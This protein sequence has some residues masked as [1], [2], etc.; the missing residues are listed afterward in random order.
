MVRRFKE[1][2]RYGLVCAGCGCRAYVTGTLPNERPLGRPLGRRIPVRSCMTDLAARLTSRI[3]V[4]AVQLHP[5]DLG[6]A[7]ASIKRLSVVLVALL[8]VSGP[9]RAQ[10]M[11]MFV[12]PLG[13]DAND[14][15]SEAA[16]CSSIQGSVDKIRYGGGAYIKLAPGTYNDA[17]ISVVYHRVV[18]I[19][20]DCRD[21]TAV[22]VNGGFQ[23]Q[24][25]AIMAPQCLT[26]NV[27]GPGG[28][29]VAARSAQ[30][31]SKVNTLGG[32]DIFGDMSYFAYAADGSSI[33]L[34]GGFTVTRAR[35]FSEAFVAGAWG[36]RIFAQGASFAWAIPATGLKFTL[37]DA[38]LARP[39][40][41]GL[42]GSLPG[43]ADSRSVVY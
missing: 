22:V 38:V 36:A 42:P 23:A 20:G 34:N 18:M 2:M 10:G 29:G 33:S 41:N 1:I 32:I 24:D 3:G 39:S 17:Q 25:H 31:I 4:V 26:I 16:P 7:L 27:G 9:V 37:T 30:E 8:A 11:E 28:I 15:L 35:N 40:G 12:S 43:T 19:V 5:R 6:I 14:C 21:L 13:S